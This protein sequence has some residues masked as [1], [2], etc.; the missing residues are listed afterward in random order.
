MAS[1][2]HVALETIFFAGSN[3]LHTSHFF[4]IVLYICPQSKFRNLKEAN[5]QLHIGNFLKSVS[6]QL[7][8]HNSAIAIFFH[9][10][11]S[12]NPQLLKEMLLRNSISADKKIV[13]ELRLRPLKIG[14]PH[15]HNY[16]PDLDS[17]P[18]GFKIIC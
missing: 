18:Q 12:S 10:S 5:L 8:I 15:F 9:Q 16:Q 1:H 11:A 13:A 14:L 3:I 2:R 17:N 7:H 4:F 6:P